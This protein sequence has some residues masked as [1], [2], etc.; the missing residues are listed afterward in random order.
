MT[1]TDIVQQSLYIQNEV[2]FIS[3]SQKPEDFIVVSNWSSVL[4]E[5][6]ALS[7]YDALSICAYVTCITRS[8]IIT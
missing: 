6:I 4:R 5:Y 1:I 7:Q 3:S 2:Q 8:Y